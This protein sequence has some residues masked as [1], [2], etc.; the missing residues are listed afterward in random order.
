MLDLKIIL[1]FIK[2]RN[3]LENMSLKYSITLNGNLNDIIVEPILVDL[4]AKYNFMPITFFLATLQN[5]LV[6]KHM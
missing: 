4:G 1:R 2:L 5:K 3:I 6:L